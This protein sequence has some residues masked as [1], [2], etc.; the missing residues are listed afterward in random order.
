MRY[1]KITS[2]SNPL[3]RD[4]L[5]RKQKREGN[6]LIIEGRRLVEMAL[7]SGADIERVFFTETFR[8]KNEDFLARLA[9]KASE[10]IEASEHVLSK[11][12]DT[13]TPQGIGVLVKYQ[14]RSLSEL[15]PGPDL[16]VV[17][18]DGIQDP[19]NLGTIIR[20]SDAV[21][22]DAVILLPGTC[23][24]FTPKGIRATAGSIFNLPILFSEPEALVAWLR[25]KSAGLIVSDMRAQT[26]IYEADMRRS[27]ALVFG[28][29]AEGVSGY[30]RR[31]ADVTVSI[32]ILGKAESLNVAT[33]AAVCLY[34]AVRQRRG[35]T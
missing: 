20:T 19:G 8:S 24:P 2:A 3:V 31:R 35:R 14:G 4:I 16:F 28:N 29:E 18:C 9:T 6:D 12:T 30:L 21:G 27:L 15:S 26:T 7:L 33:S 32:P 11:V 25:E 22:A 5:K 1:R 17:V 13:K 23:D 10:L 34:E